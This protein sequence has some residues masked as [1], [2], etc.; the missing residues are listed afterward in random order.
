MISRSAA[1]RL[2]HCPRSDPSHGQRDLPRGVRHRHRQ[3]HAAR[4][5]RAPGCS[6]TAASSRATTSSKRATGSRFPSRPRSSTRSCSPTPTSTTPGCC[7][8]SR[9]TASP[10]RS[11]APDRPAPLAALVLEDAAELQE[12]EA[13]FAAKKGY[14]RHADPRPLFTAR[15]A[16][17]RARPA[18]S[19]SRS[20]PSAR[21]LPG[22]ACPLPA[23][24]PP[25]RAPPRST[26]RAKGGDGERRS[27]CF[28]G[29]VGRYDVPILYDPEPPAAPAGG[30]AA[31]V[32]LRRPHP[33]DR[34][35]G[36]GARAESSSA[37]F[38]RGGSVVDPGLRARPHPGPA[39][40]PLEPGRRRRPR[41]R[42]RSSSTV[43][44]RSRPPRSTAT[45]PGVR[46][47]AARAGAQRRQPAR[48]RPLPAL[49]HG[50]GVEGA[51]RAHASRW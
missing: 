49:P 6:S 36:G 30:A 45:P 8:G 11:T 19:R 50:R 42:A 20:T 35:P 43:R 23:R 44:W 21:S 13:R 32:D 2:L 7:R 38:A 25:A 14:S 31:R 40:P 28:S 29:D 10:G 5:G 26:S 9:R 12:E 22:I 17:A 51:Q 46:R 18:S 1:G 34:G 37:T 15:D 47:G 39:L 27:W 24:R 4:L 41:S 48:R 16:R 33:P 3:L